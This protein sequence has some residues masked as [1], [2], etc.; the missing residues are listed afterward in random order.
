MAADAFY[1]TLLLSSTCA[2]ARPPLFQTETFLRNLEWREGSRRSALRSKS[3]PS[4]LPVTMGE[5]DPFKN[6]TVC[7][8]HSLSLSLALS[9]KQ[10]KHL[11]EEELSGFCGRPTGTP[12]P[13]AEAPFCR[14]T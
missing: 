11:S 3:K 7:F 1:R 2:A 5:F 13:Q 12:A 14:F 10:E 4:E 8:L 9:L 6:L